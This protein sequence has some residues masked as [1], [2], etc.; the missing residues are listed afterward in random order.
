LR[1]SILAKFI[2]PNTTCHREL[3][4]VVLLSRSVPAYALH[5]TSLKFFMNG[6]DNPRLFKKWSQYQGDME[7]L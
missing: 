3:G 4:V 2:C 5:I 6:D 1:N 7:L